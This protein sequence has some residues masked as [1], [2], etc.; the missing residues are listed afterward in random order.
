MARWQRNRD[1]ARYL[2]FGR[3]QGQE[4]TLRGRRVSVAID[5]NQTLDV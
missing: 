1:I 3:Y 4:Q 5:P 2:F